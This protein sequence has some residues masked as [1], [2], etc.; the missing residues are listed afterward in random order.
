MDVILS[1]LKNLVPYSEDHGC[2]HMFMI[3]YRK[4]IDNEKKYTKED[5][6]LLSFFTDQFHIICNRLTVENISEIL[7]DFRELR[8]DCHEQYEI[9]KKRGHVNIK[10]F[11]IIASGQVIG[12]EST[13]LPSKHFEYEGFISCEL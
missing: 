6:E 2:L 3:L 13:R 8:D 7:D 4:I 11:R 10:P 12:F 1:I 9:L 5:R